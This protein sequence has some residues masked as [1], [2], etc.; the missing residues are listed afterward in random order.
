[1]RQEADPQSQAAEIIC[2]RHGNAPAAL[3]EILH[4]IQEAEGAVPQSA[5]PVIAK[6]LNISR[7]EVHGVMSFYHDFRSEPAG[8]VEVKLCHAEACQSRGANALIESFCLRH[9]VALGETSRDGITVEAVYCLGNCALGPA[10]MIDG[11]LHG[12]LDA[13]RLDA[14]VQEAAR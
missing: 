11:E 9:G 14:L 4:D 6:A 3:I 7:A 2:A 5:L 1:V 8:R 13:R 10:A 12:R